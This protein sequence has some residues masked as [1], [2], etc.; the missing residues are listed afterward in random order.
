[1]LFVSSP[2]YQ[3]PWAGRGYVLLATLDHV[4]LGAAGQTYTALISMA[5]EASLNIGS[6]S[7]TILLEQSVGLR[8]SLGQHSLVL[9]GR[10]KSIT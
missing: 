8:A 5:E 2:C 10:Q 1:M 7:N 9:H 3:H 6:T 4:A